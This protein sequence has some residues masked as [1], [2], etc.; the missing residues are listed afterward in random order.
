M[1]DPTAK[2]GAVDYTRLFPWVQ[3]FRAFSIAFEFRK[4]LM[5]GLA[6]LAVSIGDWLL[7]HLFGQSQAAARW[8]WDRGLGYISGATLLQ[9]RALV[10][11]PFGQT[12]NILSNWSVVLRPL[13]LLVDP[14]AVLFDQASLGR[15]AYELSCLAWGLC[16]WSVCAGAL[17]RM[18][19]FQFARD[20]QLGMRP[21][22]RFSAHRLLDYLCAPG[23]ALVAAAGL[24]GVCALLGLIGRIPGIGALLIGLC[25]FIPLICGFLM[26]L[27]LV[28]LLIG[29]PLMFA[30][31][32]VERGDGFEA[33]SR[34]FSYVYDRPW[35]YVWLAVVA[36]TYGSL[37][38][39]VVDC[40]AQ[41]MIFLSAWSVG[42]G[43]GTERLEAWFEAVPGLLRGELL[44]PAEMAGKQSISSWGARLV[45][46]WVFAVHL[47]VA[48][49]V[50]SYFWAATTIIYFLLRRASDATDLD[51]IDVDEPGE[52][53]DLL[54][55]VRGPTVEMPPVESPA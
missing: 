42:W 14:I 32:S 20:E 24:W 11:D 49:F 27:I 51:E 13:R 35:Q 50:H 37:V 25:W 17:V 21:A 22:L 33:L 9:A 47:L 39:F 44:P 55:L 30:T 46:A 28:G 26:A 10:S 12:A 1:S 41:L 3:I 53:D 29:W 6:V 54:A 48:G 40:A 16:V 19:A 36:V 5:A 18:A 52:T 23:F 31:V 38:I 4:L 15:M 8:P 45:T 7:A 43:L 34:S 2:P